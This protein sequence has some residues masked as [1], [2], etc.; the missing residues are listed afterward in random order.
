MYAINIIIIYNLF[1]FIQKSGGYVTHTIGYTYNIFLYIRYY[2][3]LFMLLQKSGGYVTRTALTSDLSWD[4][5]RADIAL[6]H[7]VKEGMAWVDTQAADDT[8]Y[9][10]PGLFVAA[11]E[12]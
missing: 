9:W 11:S 7:L 8:Q 3:S 5:H 4:T 6:Q 12:R 2:D 1:I 10:F